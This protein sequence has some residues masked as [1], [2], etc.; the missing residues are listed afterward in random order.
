MPIMKRRRLLGIFGV[1]VATIA[2]I[3]GA[4]ALF[5]GGRSVSTDN[6]YTAVEVAQVTPLVGGPVV[7]VEV[8]DSQIVRA[9]DVLLRLD[10]TDNRIAVEHAAAAI[11]RARRRDRQLMANDDSFK[12]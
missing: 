1:T 12:A 9:G 7:S 2:V 10:E 4:W 11:A 8:I 6:A 3:W 5:F